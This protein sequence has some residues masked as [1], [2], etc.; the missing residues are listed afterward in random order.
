MKPTTYRITLSDGVKCQCDAQSA[1][2][3][4]QKTLWNYRGRKVVEIHSGFNEDEAKTVRATGAPATVGGIWFDVP[5]HEAVPESAVQ[6]KRARKVDDTEPM[7]A[8]KQYGGR[9]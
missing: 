3:A 5:D 7:F 9:G 8:E 4:I 1:G 6:E 2:E